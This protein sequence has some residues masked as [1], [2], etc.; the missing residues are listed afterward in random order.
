MPDDKSITPHLGPRV[1]RM[2]AVIDTMDGR[3]RDTE[4][5]L[6]RGDVRLEEIH[7]DLGKIEVKL[8][9][10]PKIDKRLAEINGHEKRVSSLE[11]TRQWVARAV[12]SA[13]IAGVMGALYFSK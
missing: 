13:V 12:I 8:E 5:R 4:N 6:A 3:M 10:L 7:K 1:E 11:G 2:E 9:L